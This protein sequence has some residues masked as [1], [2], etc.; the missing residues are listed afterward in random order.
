MSMHIFWCVI[1]CIL[2]NVHTMQLPSHSRYSTFPTPFKGPVFPSQSIPLPSP[3]PDK[4]WYVLFHCNLALPFLE[5]YKWSHTACTRL[6]LSSFNVECVLD[7]CSQ[8]CISHSFLFYSWIVFHY[9]NTQYFT[10]LPADEH[11]GCF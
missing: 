10:H 9:M 8:E 7:S 6:C 5:L 1:Q 4:H 11:L 3:N 2:V